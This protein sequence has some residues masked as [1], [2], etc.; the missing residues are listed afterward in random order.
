MEKNQELVEDIITKDLERQSS[1]DNYY[2]KVS[3]IS[4]AQRDHMKLLTSHQSQKVIDMSNDVLNN[5]A[6]DTYNIPN[7]QSMQ[8]L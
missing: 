6:S 1:F 4:Y 2:Q 5:C 7:A 3:S 8:N